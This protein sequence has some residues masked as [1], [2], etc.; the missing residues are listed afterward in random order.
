MK[1]RKKR[2][3]AVRKRGVG[4]REIF[5]IYTTLT[6]ARAAAI[7]ALKLEP[8]DWHT[9]EI[10]KCVADEDGWVEKQDRLSKD[11]VIEELDQ[12]DVPRDT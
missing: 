2:L 8:D 1:T 9:M 7:R 4:P 5:G 12:K 6:K 11:N 3:F 10:V